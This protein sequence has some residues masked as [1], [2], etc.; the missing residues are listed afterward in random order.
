MS[1]SPSRCWGW[2]CTCGS[3]IVDTIRQLRSASMNDLSRET[4]S[5]QSPMLRL[6]ANPQTNARPANPA[7]IFQLDAS[8]ESGGAWAGVEQLVEAAYLGLQELGEHAI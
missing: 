1:R 5:R 7:R 4:N 6:I 2:G 3:K 8:F